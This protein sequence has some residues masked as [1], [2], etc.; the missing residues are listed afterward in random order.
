MDQ[1]NLEPGQ[2]IQMTGK[3]F[4]ARRGEITQALLD[5]EFSIKLQI[6]TGLPFDK[7]RKKQDMERLAAILGPIPVAARLL[8]AF[9]VDNPEEI[10][11]LVEGYQEFMVY[12]QQKQ[13]EQE[14]Q[15]KE[16]PAAGAV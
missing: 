16:Q 4:D 11:M 10:L 8:E 6:G 12:L 9:E 14:A 7:E 13:E 3:E 5:L 2:I 1:A 15:A